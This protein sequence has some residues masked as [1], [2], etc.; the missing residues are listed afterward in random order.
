V[1]CQ[2]DGEVAD[3]ARRAGDEDPLSWPEAAVDEQA[4][5]GAVRA[6][7]QCRGL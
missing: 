3:A 5:L 7:R 6:H 1:A 2:L 4:L